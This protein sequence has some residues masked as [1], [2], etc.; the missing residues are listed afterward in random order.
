[1]RYLLSAILVCTLIGC[2]PK[3][4]PSLSDPD[5]M[6]SIPAIRKAADSGD[7]QARAKLVELLDSDDPAIRFYA[8]EALQRIA[9]TRMGYDYYGEQSQRSEA[10][11]RWRS[12]LTPAAPATASTAGEA[13]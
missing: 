7:P 2:V 8:I 3:G 6:L 11:K 5:P 13:P 4:K 12:W 1:M 10:V 9:G